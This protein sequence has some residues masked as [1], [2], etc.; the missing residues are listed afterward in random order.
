MK[1]HSDQLRQ[2]G[3]HDAIG[4]PMDR[5]ILCNAEQY[6]V[7]QRGRDGAVLQCSACKLIFVRPLPTPSAH[8][9]FHDERY[10]RSFYDT[11]IEEFHTHD[12]PLY[13]L[14][15]RV[16]ANRLK[17]IQ[18]IAMSGRL[19]DVGTGQG[20]FPILAQGSGWESWAV[21][22]SEYVCAYLATRG[23]H[24]QC[25]YVEELRLPS[26]YF[27]VITLWHCLEHTFNPLTTLQ[28]MFG[29]LKIGGTVFIEVRRI[30]MSEIWLRK[31]LRRPAFALNLDE[32]HFYHFTP[33]TLSRLASKAGFD[34]LRI[35]HRPVLRKALRGRLI[36]GV[37][38]LISSTRLIDLH[39]TVF[40]VGKKRP[41]TDEA[42]VSPPSLGS[43]G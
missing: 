9:R 35:G 24:V 39:S 38:N 12:G 31:L 22:I 2:L 19:L 21:D 32:W 10:F 43:L 5:C 14:E 1:V 42:P 16:K 34:I 15:K 20:L 23:I 11:G 25:G 7:L 3:E 40:L 26:D 13:Q 6:Q 41:I 33:A 28:T 18:S 17:L 8:R 4:V 27:D 30:S 36:E 37:R 29:A